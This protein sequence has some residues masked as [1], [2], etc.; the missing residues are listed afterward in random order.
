MFQITQKNISCAQ[1]LYGFLREL[2]LLAQQLQHMQ[3]GAGAQVV[4]APAAYHLEHLSDEFNFADA[5]GAELDIIEAVAP[6]H[7]LTNLRMKFAHGGECAEVEI[8][9]EYKRA[10]ELHQFVIKEFAQ[11]F[12][13][14]FSR[15][16]ERVRERACNRG[17][18]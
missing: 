2:S 11:R 13:C 10:R 17:N 7:F 18:H 3:S 12:V 1:P 6:L 9:T 4:I 5:A 16:R 14:P 15:R 8:F